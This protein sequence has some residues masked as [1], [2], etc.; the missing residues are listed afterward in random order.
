MKKLP[1]VFLFVFTIVVSIT[2]QAQNEKETYPKI[3]GFVGILHPLVTFSSN[4]TLTNFK[5]YY[6]VGMPIGINIWKSEKIGFSFEIVPTI[7]SD[8]QVSKVSNILIHPGLLVR[9]KKGFTFAGRVAFE[10]SG[11]FGFT[12]I[13]AKVIKKYKDHNYY[14]SM[15]V[16]VRFG[17][18]N[19]PTVTVGF[20]VG[21][22]F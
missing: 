15:P 1:L 19:E 20:Q 9:L 21:I 5:D 7:K 18:N 2:A 3:T 10:T 22:G 6:A 11:R 17:N 8:N 14:V 16:P 13:L 12:P 4:E